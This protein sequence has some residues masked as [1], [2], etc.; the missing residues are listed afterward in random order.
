MKTTTA[1]NT[2]FAKRVAV[3]Y[4]SMKHEPFKP[5]V[6]KAYKALSREVDHQYQIVL[7][8]GLSIEFYPEGK[9]VYQSPSEAVEDIRRNKH[10][11]VLPTSTDFGMVRKYEHNP[12]LHGTGRKISGLPACAND[13]FRVVHDYFGHYMGKNGFRALG[14]ENA[15]RFHKDMFSPL[16]IKALTTETRGQNSWVNYGPYG[17]FNREAKESETIFA[18]QKTGLLPDFCYGDYK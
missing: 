8:T 4:D 3:A 13:L 18:D 9:N 14:E 1:I 17:D 6:R 2:D 12:M 15:Y 10:L 5:S 7:N 16:A 11:Y